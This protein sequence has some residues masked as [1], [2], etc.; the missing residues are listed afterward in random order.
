MNL[1][2]AAIGVV[3]WAQDLAP[4]PAPELAKIDYWVGDWTA[5]LKTSFMGQTGTMKSNVTYKKVLG[6]L[7][8]QGM[9]EYIMDPSMKMTGMHVI[10]YD[11]ANKHWVSYWFDQSEPGAMEM[12]GPF[13]GDKIVM[14]SKPTKTQSMPGEIVMRASYIKKS[15][16]SMEFKL[17]MKE[18]DKWAPMMEGTYT[19]K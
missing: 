11:A 13:D 9:H 17:E 4:K 10:S 15:A 3:A 16:K 2:V 14:V 7:H 8:L 6:G 12:T 1:L 19:K 5:T 18:G